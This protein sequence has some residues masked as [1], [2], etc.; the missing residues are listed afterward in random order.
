[1]LS[2]LSVPDGTQKD[3]H[4]EV[5]FL[6]GNTKLVKI[7]GLGNSV[8]YVRSNSGKVRESWVVPLG[9]Q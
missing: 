3:L 4:I 8:G 5:E 1:M 6:F 2:G 7:I 9:E